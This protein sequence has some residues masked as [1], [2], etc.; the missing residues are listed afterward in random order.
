MKT[1]A[2]VLAGWMQLL[3]PGFLARFPGDR[4]CALIRGDAELKR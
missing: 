3:T 1:F 2:V 4:R